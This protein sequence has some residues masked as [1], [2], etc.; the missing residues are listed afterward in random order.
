M[1]DYNRNL[2]CF[3]HIKSDLPPCR[4]LVQGPNGTVLHTGDVR[5]EPA[6][7]ESLKHNPHLQ[8]YI[9]PEVS[10]GSSANSPLETL[11]AIYLDTACMLGTCEVPPKV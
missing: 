6:M 1:Y 11:E 8:R 2:F 3:Q 9:V 7:I 5:S 4:Y 10:Y